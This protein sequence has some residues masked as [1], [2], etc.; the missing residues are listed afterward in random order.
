MDVS[1]ARSW[2]RVTLTTPRRFSP[3]IN[4]ALMFVLACITPGFSQNFAGVLTQHNDNG[5]TGQNLQETTLTPQN[6]NSTGFGKLFSYSVDGQIYAQPLYVPNVSIPNQGIHN[7]IYVTTQNDTVYAFDADGLNSAPLWQDSFVNPAAGI[8]PVPCGTDGSTSI[9]CG[10]YPI[11][12]ITGTP[13]IDPYTNTMYLVARTYE[14]SVGVQRLHALDLGSGAEKF[15]GPVVIAASVPGTG[16]GHTKANVVNFNPLADIQRAGLLLVNGTVYIGWAGAQHGWIMGYSAQ[17]STQT[18]TQVAAFNTTPNSGS[19]GIW[20][21]GNGLAADTSGNIFAAVGDATFDANSGGIDYGDSVLKLNG[22]LQVLDYFAPMDQACRAANDKDLGSAGPM[23]LPAQPGP[24]P[25][26]LIVAGKGGSPCQASGLSLIYLINQNGL[27]AYNPSQDQVVQEISGTT[28]GYFSS[29]AYWQG[30]GGTNLYLA[31][32]GAGQRVGDYLKM[33]SL[34]NGQLSTAPVAQSTNPFTVGSTPSVSA[35]GSS[36]GIV[37]AIERQDPLGT[38]S[39]TLPAILYAYD[40][41]NVST[42]LYNSAQQQKRDQGG[43]GNKFQVPTIANGKVYVGTQNEVD[44]FGLLPNN[45]PAAPGINL[46]V[47]CEVFPSQAVGTTSKVRSVVLTNIGNSQTTPLEITGVAISGP[48]AADF[49]QTNNCSSLAIGALCTIS[50]TFTPSVAHPESAYV[51]IT[52]N[53]AGSPHNVY[54]VGPGSVGTPVVNWPTPAPITYGTALSSTQLN[55]TAN[56]PGTFAYSPPAG[57]VLNTGSQ[58]LSVTFTPNDTS[59]YTTAT[60]T[61]VLQVNPGTTVVTWATPAPI[62][63]PTALSATQLNATANVP[64]TF[65]YSPASGT[66]LN[67]GSQTLSVTFTPTDTTHYEPVTTTVAL[68]VN[69]ASTAVTWAPPAPITYGTVLSGSQLNATANVPGSFTYSP[70]AGS[71]LGAGSQSLSVTF[72]PTDGT[73]YTSSNAGVTLQVNQAGLVATANPAFGAYGQ[74]LPLLYYTITGFVNGD[75]QGSA[76]S[77]APSL[78]TAAAPTSPPGIYPIAI[79]QG[80]LAAANYSFASFV[81]GVLTIQQ[82]GSSVVLTSANGSISQGQ[83]TALTATVSIT[84]A[85]AAPTQSVNFMLGQTLLGR[86]TLSPLDATDSA[87]TFTLNASQLAAGN[88][89]ITA[90]YAG[91]TN[92]AGS[93]SAAIT[94]TL[95]STPGNFG[96]VNVGTTASIETLTYTFSNPATLAAVN[97][98]TAGASS[99]DYTDGGSSTCAAGTAYNTGDSCLVTVAFKPASAGMRSGAVTLFAQGSNLPLMTWYLSGIGQSAEVVIDPGTQSTLATL[100]SNG[101]GYGS[102]VDGGGNVYVVDYVNSQVIELAAGTFAPSTVVSAGLSGPTAVAMDGAGNLYVSDTGN[103]RVVMVPNENGALNSSDLSTV[104]I[105]GLGAPQGL[106]TDDNG[107]LYVADSVNGAVIE[108]PAGGGAPLTVASGLTNPQGVAVD[109]VGNVYVAG[110]NQ[111]V[112]YPVGGGSPIPMGSG[113]ANP[114]SVALDAS[115]AAYVADPGNSRIVR[116]SAGGISQANMAVTGLISPRSVTVDAAGSLY[117]TDTS[118][119]YEVNRTQAVPLAFATTNVGST[120]APQTVTVSNAGNQLLTMSNLAITANF[121]Q[122]PSGGT[123]CASSAQL[124]SGGQCL[125]ATEFAPTT[126]G[127]LTGTLTLSDSALNTASTQAVQLAGGG[128][129]A[130]QTITFAAIPP[131]TYGGGAVPLNATASSSLPV[132]FSVTSGPATVSGNLLIVTGVGSVTVQASQAGNAGYAPATPVAQTFVV[133]PAATTITWGAPTPITYGTALGAPQLNAT[134]NVPGSFVYS[135]P[136]GAV[137]GAGSQTLSVS[138]TPTDSADYNSSSGSVTLQV[139]PAATTVTWAQPAP[140]TYGTALGATQL[141]ATANVPGSFLYAPPSG[142]V[143]NAGSQT[144]SVT[145]T[146]TDGT[147][148]SSS[149]GAVTLQVNPASQVIT[150]TQNAPAVAPYNTSFTVAAT[151][152]SG[153]PVS[154]ISSG[155]C[156]NVGGAFTITSGSG[157]CTVTALQSGNSNYLAAP[158]VKEVVTA[159]KATPTVTFTG[160]PV[161]APY[162]ST[163]TVT[164]TAN[165]GVTPA[166]TTNSACSISGTTV[167]MTSGTGK[168]TVTAKWAATAYFLAASASQT[169]T[170]VKL[171]PTVIW[172]TPAPITYG[173]ALSGSQLNATSN[174][175]GSFVYSPSAGTVLGAGSQTLSVTFTP[176][177]TQNY[178]T[179]T[180]KVTLVVNKSATSTVITSNSPN[181][182]KVGKAVTVKVTVTPASGYGTPTSHVTVNASTGETCTATLTLGSGTCSV[183]FKSTG[184]RTLTATYG[185]DSNDSTSVS[186]GVTQTVN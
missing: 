178:T 161:S 186:A 50:I 146:P 84:G 70:A 122:V 47:P 68:Q 62:S 152:S 153:L 111:V 158:T 52:D 49:A 142:T 105:S 51:M 46:S 56:V 148:Y 169:T 37:W 160:A 44:V 36:A 63:Y 54:L 95:S 138:F 24:F 119:V 136:A 121:V 96:S 103:A 21:S 155:V 55:A 123:D 147:D 89:S 92:Y 30:E 183:T 14:N 94:V 35:N 174:V 16:T 34:T 40:A 3:K 32:T 126:S 48:G 87:A 65:V 154:F 109:T 66:V 8:I 180:V 53:A 75:T 118:S 71:V 170:A 19:G 77:G 5:R 69:Q 113:Y 104:T 39:G 172:A 131:Q 15:G 106:A 141:N 97:I 17:N 102:V 114:S 149:N 176:T 67:A 73:D 6:V 83:S 134:A 1:A 99:H 144:L 28:G 85:G 27:G 11:Y 29:P 38:I 101:Q 120:S 42:M 31:G 115:G 12:G 165:S 45:P 25:D 22:S 130:A 88:N 76:T 157:T 175:A 13:V 107:N 173:T 167:T 2:R 78:G 163:F 182:S 61:A 64:G 9:A 171:L 79:A 184:S 156:S 132:S 41:T 124:S 57:S 74:A 137:L 110:N 116:V 164:A 59:D 60:A 98:L 150:F 33:Y 23:L 125:V 168:C 185:G 166:I 128:A 7:V 145:F 151:A 181:P 135:P 86:E 139:N 93:T 81:N 117:I 91:D 4:A 140:I 10:V 26:E 159:A 133:N 127:S 20:A 80:T 90:V 177:L 112:E 143:L 18:L 43:C 58:T 82:S 100:S 129:Q 179:S 108:V 162:Q 72:T